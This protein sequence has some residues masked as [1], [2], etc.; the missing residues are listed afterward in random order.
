MPAD[1]SSLRIGAEG[2]TNQAYGSILPAGAAVSAQQPGSTPLLLSMHLSP[3]RF[4]WALLATL[5][6]ALG[7]V[8]LP[9]GASA[10]TGQTTY[11]EAPTELLSAK[12][13]PGA[14]NTISSLGVH[15]LRIVMYWR[16]VA[17]SPTSTAVPKVDLTN[18]ANYNWG[19]YAALIT[20]A[21][22]LHW[23]IML[24]VSGPVPRWATAGHKDYLTRPDP[25]DFQNFMT[26]VGREFSSQVSLWAIWNEP[27]HPFFLMPQFNSNG[28]PAS[29]LIYRSLWQSAYKGLQA[30]GLKSPKVLFGDTAPTGYEHTTGS[31]DVAPI[32][33][34]QGALCL[35]SSYRMASTC[36]KLPI[37]GWAHHAYG[38][39]GGPYVN[40]SD[41]NDV[42]IDSLSR[43]TTALDRAARAGAIPAGV[44]VYLTEFGWQTKPN[45]DLAVSPANQAIFDAV[46]EHIAY[47]NPRVAAFSQ[48]LLRDDPLGG[49]PGASV[50]GG[51][52]GFQTGLE[53]ISGQAKPLLNGFRLP[54]TVARSA[55]SS[56]SLW[57]LVR[58]ATGATHV[59]VLVLPK[60]SRKSAS[61]SSS[62]RTD[63]SGYWTL[64]TSVRNPVS[65]TVRWRA[66]SGTIY[67]SA[68]ITPYFR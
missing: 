45:R 31:H 22:A 3:R 66:P 56:Y 6:L 41:P 32:T 37:Y 51:Y 21:R 26:A 30:S 19:Q 53:Y 48:Y 44:P 8:A 58:P 2:V 43:L 39:R 61:L 57:G 62:V 67:T 33:F 27:D 15:A 63:S 34:L 52:V 65:F 14:L 16:N 55:S 38:L 35:N 25:L 20:A 64:R 36:S 46:S 59:E 50:N 13:R 7:A 49:A 4:G 17:P 23:S 18:P 24:N 60:G 1:R 47:D 54:L 12:L 40:W 42:T 29:P 68:P 11:F 9:A 28:T 10:S 5:M